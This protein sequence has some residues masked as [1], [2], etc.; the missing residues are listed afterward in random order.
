MKW[1]NK[2][3][4]KRWEKLQKIHISNQSLGSISELWYEEQYEKLNKELAKITLKK[5]KKSV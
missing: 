3:F 2:K 1:F 4:P 5:E